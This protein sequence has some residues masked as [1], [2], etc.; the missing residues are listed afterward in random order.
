MRNIVFLTFDKETPSFRH[1]I[2]PIIQKLK[3]K[4]WKCQIKII[5]RRAYM[6]RFFRSCISLHKPD[7][8]VLA[9]IL[10][11]FGEM[12][13]L[14]T[15]AQSVVIDLDDAIYLVKPRNIVSEP[16]YSKLRKVRFSIACR[17]A[18][19]ITTGNSILAAEAKKYNSRVEIVP[20]G[21]DLKHRIK[22]PTN[23]KKK[24]RI[25]WIGLP[26]NLMYLEIV[27]PCL[28][29]LAGCFK[30]MLL[31]VVCSRFPDWDDIPIE[32]VKWTKKGE[33]FAIAGADIG[34]MPLVDDMW[35]RGKCGFKLLQY[36][37]AGLPCVASPV[38]VNRNIII[39]GKT[40][41]LA[42][43]EDE[44]CRALSKLLAFSRKRREMGSRGISRV[45]KEF[46]SDAIANKVVGF[47]ESLTCQKSIRKTRSGV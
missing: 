42:K 23:K 18:N 43:N 33:P 27:K 22:R 9:K 24:I 4:K 5:S 35:T 14:K 1:R 3:R 26:E 21:I 46:D 45:A 6:W 2:S 41:F 31:R 7:I 20:T 30:N 17:L 32:R 13:L 25:V 11:H 29:R 38:G 36:M 16:I 39:D 44:W 34:I 8:V 37:A 19:L 47:Y 15:L 40:G 28:I 12:L 10:P